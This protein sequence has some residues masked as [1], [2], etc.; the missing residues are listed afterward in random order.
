MLDGCDR[1]LAGACRGCV[2]GRGGVRLGASSS[3]IRDVRL[4][5]VDSVLLLGIINERVM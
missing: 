1:L 2:R 5:L 4:V 3:P